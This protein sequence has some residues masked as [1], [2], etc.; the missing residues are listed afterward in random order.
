MAP[1]NWILPQF[2]ASWMSTHHKSQSLL[3]QETL[4]LKH[5]TRTQHRREF[6]PCKFSPIESTLKTIANEQLK[7]QRI[8]TFYQIRNV[9]AVHIEQKLFWKIAV[10]A[11]LLKT[12][13]V[14]FCFQRISL[15]PVQNNKEITMKG[16]KI[17]FFK[18]RIFL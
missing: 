16:L 13:I 12:S 2:D 1:I 8:E 17:H 14:D 3:I 10:E 11:I 9:F 4:K 6:M 7:I 18:N 15:N 5:R